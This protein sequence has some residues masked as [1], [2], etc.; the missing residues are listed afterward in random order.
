MGDLKYIVMNTLGHNANET[1]AFQAFSYICLPV[2]E[3]KLIVRFSVSWT[4]ALLI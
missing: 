2:S 4:N 3:Y 1:F